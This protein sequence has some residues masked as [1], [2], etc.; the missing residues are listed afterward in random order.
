MAS[1][2]AYILFK[3]GTIFSPVSAGR[4]DILARSSPFKEMDA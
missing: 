2:I 4:G 1:K 3:D